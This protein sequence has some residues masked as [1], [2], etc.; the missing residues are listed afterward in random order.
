M[1]FYI[2][3]FI[4]LFIPLIQFKQMCFC[5]FFSIMIIII[6]WDAIIFIL[7]NRIYK[8]FKC[9]HMFYA[10]FFHFLS[11]SRV[12]STH[13]HLA[14]PPSIHIDSRK[15][16]ISFQQIFNISIIF[17]LSFSLTLRSYKI[18]TY[19]YCKYFFLIFYFW[20]LI[21]FSHCVF[22]A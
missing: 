15:N 12:L 8:I 14:S 4:I 11:V 21:S 19:K 2:F 16:K 17:F 5:S 18:P 3:F 22:F 20:F 6:I 9:K 10:W 13:C 1:D 7:Y